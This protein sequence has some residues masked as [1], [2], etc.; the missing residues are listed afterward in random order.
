MM[1]EPQ[2]I[3][4]PPYEIPGVIVMSG[5]LAENRTAQPLNNIRIHIEYDPTQAHLHHIQIVADDEY[6]LRGG[7]GGS[8]FATVRLRQMRAGGKVF[9][10]FAATKPI[11]PKVSVTSWDGR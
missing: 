11:D 5:V 10:Y 8:S 7:G 4:L 6:I 3:I 1:K 2:F 9:V